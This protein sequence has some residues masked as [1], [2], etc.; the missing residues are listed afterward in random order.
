VT[1]DR[2][3]DHPDHLVRRALEIDVASRLLSADRADLRI[4]RQA[5]VASV[6]T[7][8]VTISLGGATIAGV[9]F[10]TSYSPVAGDVVFIDFAGPD[11]IVI[12]RLDPFS[13]MVPHTDSVGVASV[14]SGN[15]TSTTGADYPGPV[16]VTNFVKVLAATKLIVDVHLSWYVNVANTRYTEFTVALDGTDQTWVRAFTN[17]PSS[18]KQFSQHWEIGGVAAGTGKTIKLRWRTQNADEQA[19]TDNNDHAS[20]TVTETF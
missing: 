15:T 1:F 18:H 4:R 6:Q 2:G 16:Q 11:P 10:L 17:E 12:G 19:V 8:S 7:G 9:K 3:D 5:T 13:V 20:M 14:T